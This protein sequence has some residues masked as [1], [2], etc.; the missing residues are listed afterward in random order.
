MC[1]TIA[2]VGNADSSVLLNTN[3]VELRPEPR[4]DRSDRLSLLPYGLA[5]SGKR[6]LTSM[7]DSASFPVFVED[8]FCLLCCFSSSD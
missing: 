8:A 4:A 1:R 3:M 7:F 2:N 6:L 5:D